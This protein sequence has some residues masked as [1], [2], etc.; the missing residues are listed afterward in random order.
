[1]SK[2]MFHVPCPDVLLTQRCQFR[3][4]YCFERKANRDIDPE[5]F[6]EFMKEACFTGFFP[7]GGEPLLRIDLL[8]QVLDMAD[9]FQK[10]ILTNNLI[11][12]GVLIPKYV[13]II[14]KY[15]ITVQ[16]S[17]DGPK[18]VHNK[19]R[20]YPDGRGTFDDVIKAISSCIKHKINWSIHSVC[21]KDTLPYFAES[22]KFFFKVFRLKGIEKAIT[23]MRHNTIQIVFEEDYTDKDVDILIEQFYEIAE[24]IMNE[25]NGLTKEERYNLLTNFCIRRGGHCGAGTALKVIDSDFNIYPCHRMAT[26]KERNDH[27]LGNVY[28]PKEFINY[29]IYNSYSRLAKE[30]F[31]Y[32]AVTNLNPNFQ[33]PWFMW[34]PA[35]NYETSGNIY[36]QSAKYNLV[37]TEI[38]RAIKDIKRIYKIKDGNPGQRDNC[39]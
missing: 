10:K 9:E 8:T 31:M 13:D 17:L 23:A 34:C 18:H 21:T 25:V 14:K 1:M 38:E 29:K 5:K 37:F 20:K 4:D 16:I 15:N 36:Y 33:N 6:K 28:N 11:T 19:H 39:K 35:T 32:S 22:M 30:K 7:F 2:E 3:C 24:W 12:N 26:L 27:L